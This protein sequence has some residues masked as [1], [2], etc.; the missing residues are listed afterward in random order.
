MCV[1]V[2]SFNL[3]QERD[4]EK[5]YNLLQRVGVMVRNKITMQCEGKFGIIKL[6][7]TM[8]QNLGFF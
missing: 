4:F 8:H 3:K 6:L 2:E 1:G 5:D 7:T